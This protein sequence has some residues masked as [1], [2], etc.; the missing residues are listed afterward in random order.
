M[1]LI[2]WDPG[3]LKTTTMNTGT[4]WPILSFEWPKTQVSLD[5]LVDFITGRFKN[6]DKFQN[7][8]FCILY[9]WEAQNSFK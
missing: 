2:R 9:K 3:V 4:N 6:W 7:P 8:I 1:K 5:A